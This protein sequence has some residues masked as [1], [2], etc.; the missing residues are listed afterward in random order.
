[1]L[2]YN[3]IEYIDNYSKTSEGLRQSCRDEAAVNSTNGNIMD[4]NVA[5]SIT[6]LLKLKQKQQ[7][8]DATVAQKLLI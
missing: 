2:I 8:K 6:N 7:A 1:M 4:F 5:N 3:L